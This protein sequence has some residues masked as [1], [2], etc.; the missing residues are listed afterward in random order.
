MSLNKCVFR[1]YIREEIASLGDFLTE[2]EEL[3]KIH[4]KKLNLTI[5]DLDL[6]IDQERKGGFN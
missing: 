5:E 3:S 1:S 4:L 2:Q 6:I